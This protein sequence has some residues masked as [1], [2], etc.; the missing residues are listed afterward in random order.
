MSITSEAITP[1]RIVWYEPFPGAERER[2]VISSLCTDPEFVFVRYTEGITAARTAI[3]D[4][5]LSSKE[6][7]YT[8][9]K[10]DTILHHTAL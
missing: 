4:L 1:G 8:C 7:L 6:C 3:S 2:G 5:F 9:Q 10:T